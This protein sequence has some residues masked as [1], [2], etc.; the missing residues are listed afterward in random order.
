[1]EILGGTQASRIVSTDLKGEGH[2]AEIR[3]TILKSEGRTG[4]DLLRWR[5][6]KCAEFGFA[7]WWMWAYQDTPSAKTG[8]RMLDGRWKD[9]LLR[10]IAPLSKGD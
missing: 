8:L 2:E 7:G 1:M 4:A 5:L 6:A 9:T 3:D 10:E